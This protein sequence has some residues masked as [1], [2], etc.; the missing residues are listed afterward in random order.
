MKVLFA[1]AAA[2][3]ALLTTAPLAL[4][5]ELQT[6][7]PPAADADQAPDADAARKNLTEPRPTIPGMTTLG[8]TKLGNTTIHFGA[9]RSPGAYSGNDWFLDGPAARTVPSQRE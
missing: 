7:H 4:A 6:S 1:V 9:S 2:A 5:L 3:I 8:T